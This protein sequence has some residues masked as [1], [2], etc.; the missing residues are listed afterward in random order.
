MDYTALYLS[1]MERRGRNKYER[2]YNKKKQSFENWYAHALNKEL[3]LI[4]GLETHAVFQD[5]SQ[6]NNKDLSDDKY[7]IAPNET[8]VNIGSYVTWRDRDWLVF[9]EEEKTIPTHQQLK[10]KEVN[11][12][13]KWMQDGEIFNYG[14][15]VQNQT[16]Y[17]L[18]VAFVGDLTSIVN[19]KMMMYVQNNLHTKRIRV[20]QRLYI[21]DYVYKILFAD[22]ISRNGLINFLME[23]DLE[24]SVNDNPELGIADYHSNGLNNAMKDYVEMDSE[25]NLPEEE[26]GII[27]DETVKIGSRHI[28]SI[29]EEHIVSEWI[30]EYMDSGDQPYR[31]LRKSDRELEIE[32]ANDHRNISKTFT[33]FARLSD[34]TTKAAPIRII[35]KY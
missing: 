13:I 27:G 32:I 30:V 6:S 17:T 19:A 20:G 2:S 3:C 34:G 21:G 18:G 16:L 10:I 5:H 15:Y 35:A 12:D 29:D 31:I 33:V 9:T 28:Y 25:V 11:W 1:K 23:Q 4:D 8:I 14:A 24:H 22:S 26:I 7:L